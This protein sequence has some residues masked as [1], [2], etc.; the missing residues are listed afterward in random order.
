MNLTENCIDKH[1]ARRGSES[2]IIS[3][4]ENGE[5]RTLTY[6]Q[7]AD[8]VGRLANALKRLGVRAGDAVGV[9]LPMSQEAAIAIL[10]CS[11]IGAIYPPCFSGFGAQAVATR[12]SSCE[13][14]A[15]G[16]EVIQ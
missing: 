7:L 2:A 13:A 5:T 8:E 14:R 1:L 4:A 11:R 6:A 10:A 15:Q 9:F 16:H 12:L 3:E